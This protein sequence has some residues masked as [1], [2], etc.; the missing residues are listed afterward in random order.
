MN[1]KRFAAAVPMLAGLE[2]RLPQLAD[3]AAWYFASSQSQ[4]SNYAAVVPALDPVFAQTPRSP[5]RGRAALL[6]ADAYMKLDRPQD[7]IR[8]LR[9][10]YSETT[11]P[12]SDMAL[13]DAYLATG[14]KTNA[15][16]AYQRVYFG[17]PLS[18]AAPRALAA[19]DKLK[20]DMGG[21]Y[22]PAIPFAM[23]GRAVKL[24]ES[25]QHVTARREFEALIPQLGGAERDLARVRIGVSMFNAKDDAQA[26]QYLSNLEVAGEADAERLH[27][28]VQLARRLKRVEQM[29]AW[30]QRLGELYPRSPWAVDALI[31]AGNRF[32]TENAV[33]KFEPLYQAC[34]EGAPSNPDSDLCHWK[35]TW[36]HYMRRAP[37]AT[38]MLR[39]H[40]RSY[41]ASDQASASLYFLGR[42][43]QQAG[44]NRA[45]SAYFAETSR[46]YPNVFYAG[47]AREKMLKL[48]NVAPSEAVT[49]FLKSVSFPLR[50]RTH[51]FTATG[52]TQARIRRANLL[53]RAGLKD[54]AESELRFGAD[55]GE[56]PP[57]LAMELA[58]L[59]SSGDPAKAMRYIKRYARGY[60]LMPIPSAPRDF[61]RLAFPLP[62]RA[63]LEKF[64]Q[65]YN[66]DP[67][68]TAALIR[69]ESE[70]NAQA[71]SATN[72]RGLMQVEPYTGRD[73]SRRLKVP[74]ALT[75]LFQPDFN[76]QLGTYYF[77]SLMKQWEGNL[78]A[79]LASYNA[80]PSNAKKWITWGQFREPA[81][82]IETVP[83]TQT[84]EYIQAV[85]RNA[86]TYREIYTS[87]GG[88]AAPAAAE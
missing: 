34:Y 78:E 47:L 24:L 54:L 73:L 44:D 9:D 17:Y 76:V 69:Q 10:H 59:L 40:L 64:A 28:M 70:F 87:S 29:E 45:A 48:A 33:A 86:M 7:A 1:A 31:A 6:A 23:L 37:D 71:V 79:V 85:E 38:Q 22:P 2:T 56:Q 11:P 21:D 83:I 60:L 66:V 82:F 55:A 65:Q 19:M 81:E 77:S 4:L 58:K 26:L 62:Y 67:Y 49:T 16:V 74:Y 42:L 53:A 36:Q 13:A 72:A 30:A 63:S 32:L 35:V 39:D 52:D 61:W 41:P 80:G 75:K 15:A 20:L 68:M 27:Y 18:P 46:E 12:Q 25:G 88:F 8:M 3:Y 14:D 5:L 57:V 84:R 51:D 43:A 50:S